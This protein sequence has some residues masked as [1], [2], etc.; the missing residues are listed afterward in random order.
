[1]SW[2]TAQDVLLDSCFHV[3]TFSAVHCVPSRITRRGAVICNISR[4][5]GYSVSSSQLASWA[6]DKFMV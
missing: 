5:V 4:N 6:D 1:M 2:H 3:L